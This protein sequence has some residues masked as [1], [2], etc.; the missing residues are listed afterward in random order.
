R[1]MN[2]DDRYER[3]H[4]LQWAAEGFNMRFSGGFVETSLALHSGLDRW[5]GEH[6]GY[7]DRIFTCMDGALLVAAEWRIIPRING[8]MDGLPAVMA[9]L[10]DWPETQ[11]AARWSKATFATWLRRPLE[12]AREMASTETLHRQ[13]RPRHRSRWA[14]E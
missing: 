7:E 11:T 12:F 2:E 14:P 13:G 1:T 8:L 5:L 10:P 4:A 9:H 3:W 6:E